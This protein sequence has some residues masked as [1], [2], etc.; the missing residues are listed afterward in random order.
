MQKRGVGH[1]RRYSILT[2]LSYDVLCPESAYEA[3]PEQT[4]CRQHT[5][6]LCTDARGSVIRCVM[7]TG[8]YIMTGWRLCLECRQH[9]CLICT[10]G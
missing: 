2:E 1:I 8:V 7:I 5:C 10:D 4:R 3:G 9:T 6:L